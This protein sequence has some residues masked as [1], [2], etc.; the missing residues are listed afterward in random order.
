M[1]AIEQLRD[2]YKFEFKLAQTLMA[3]IWR[4]TEILTGRKVVIKIISDNNYSPRAQKRF[5]SEIRAIQKIDS[6]YVTKSYDHFWTEDIQYLIMEY[7][8]GETLKETIESNV[9]LSVEQSVKYAKEIALGLSEIHKNGVIHR[10]IKSSNIMINN[11]DKVKI[12][13]FGT[14]LHSEAERVTVEGNIIGSAQYL[15]PELL[16]KVDASVKSDIY[17]LGIVLFEMLTGKCPFRGSNVVETAMM[18]K[19]VPMPI[20][21]EL[22]PSIPKQLSG[23]IAKATAKN[24]AYRFENADEMY[25]AL[26]K[27]EIK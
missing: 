16:D 11:D 15:A 27:I 14:A 5:L 8:H 3:S 4:A 18:H 19:K 9:R 21:S 10:D 22:L 6:E 24:L 26:C 12:I 1:K 2:K 17:S 20:A 7:I 13:D 25:Q 23:I